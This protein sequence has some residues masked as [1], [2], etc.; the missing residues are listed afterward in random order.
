MLQ[1]SAKI[2]KKNRH[3]NILQKFDNH[4]YLIIKRNLI[5]FFIQFFVFSFYVALFTI[6][7]LK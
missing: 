6:V 3:K 2:V 1:S 7:F 4:I 5:Y